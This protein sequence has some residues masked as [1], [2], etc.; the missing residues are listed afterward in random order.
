MTAQIN[1]PVFAIPT[2]FE[3]RSGDISLPALKDFLDFLRAKDARSIVV[4][5]STGEFSSLTA[6]ER[7]TIF[8]SARAVFTGYVINNISATSWREVNIFARASV[9]ADALLVLPPFYY[10]RVSE[11]GIIDFFSRALEGVEIPVYLYNFPRNVKI[12]ITPALFAR[13]RAACPVVAG[14][15]DSS[16]DLSAA[17]AFMR[18]GGAE[19][20]FLGKDTLALPA[21][22]AG[23]DGSITGAGDP[24]PE[25]LVEIAAAWRAHDLARA[26]VAQSAFDAWNAFRATLPVDEAALVKATI[27]LRLPGFPS[28]VRAP[29]APLDATSRDALTQIVQRLLAG[30]LF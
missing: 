22:R 21:L 17:V 25:F 10:G 6:H 19:S 28:G 26:E 9:G 11:Q 1:G 4:N 8:R 24:F 15:K 14:V 16:G 12:I 7:E 30:D 20:V 23:L 5:G 27:A 29:L 3:E 13:I 18:D 2:P